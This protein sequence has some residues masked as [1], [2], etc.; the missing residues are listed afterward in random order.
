MIISADNTAVGGGAKIL[1]G[2][3]VSGTVSVSLPWKPDYL[4]VY[5]PYTGASRFSIDNYISDWST[6]QVYEQLNENGYTYN[7]PVSNVYGINTV[8][9][10]G[11][12]VGANVG[13]FSWIAIKF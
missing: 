1:K 8:T 10:N 3:E 2:S 4:V 13:A 5:A 12:T 7:L 6:S 9:D 11:F